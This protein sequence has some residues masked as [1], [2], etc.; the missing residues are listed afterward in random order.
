MWVRELEDFQ[1]VYTRSFS[2]AFRND[3]DVEHLVWRFVLPQ[4]VCSIKRTRRPE[5]KR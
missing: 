3:I 2:A 5:G 4:C 1:G